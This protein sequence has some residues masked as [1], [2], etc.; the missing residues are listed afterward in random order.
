MQARGSSI[1]SMAC[2][3]LSSTLTHSALS[4]S[5]WD[6]AT[7]K[8]WYASSTF[9]FLNCTFHT[10]AILKF[11]NN[12]EVFKS[13]KFWIKLKVLTPI[14]L[15]IPFI[16]VLFGHFWVFWHFEKFENNFDFEILQALASLEVWT[17]FTRLESE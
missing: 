3:R 9:R 17:L 7:Q 16:T 10:L 4:C 13:S 11:P 5:A 6:N 12:L 1:S 15:N 8:Y 14:Y 2:E